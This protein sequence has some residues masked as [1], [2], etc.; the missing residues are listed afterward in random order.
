MKISEVHIKNFRAIKDEIISFD[1]ITT[2]IGPNGAGKSTILRALDWFFNGN[3]KTNELVDDDVNCFSEGGDIEVDITFKDLSDLDRQQLGKYAPPGLDNLT[4]RKIREFQSGDEYLSANSKGYPLFNE[5]KTA[6]TKTLK[7]DL[8]NSLVSSN[9]ELGLE[10]V[11]SGAKAEEEITAWES[12]NSE[13]LEEIP[14]KIVTQF[15]GFNGEGV[16]S[17]VFDYVLIDADLRAADESE[18]AKGSILSKIIDIFVDRSAGADEIKKI[19]E[20]IVSEHQEKITQK[21]ESSLSTLNNNFNKSI[22]HYVSGRTIN[23]VPTPLEVKAGK[24]GFSIQI[25]DGTNS[26]SVARQGH[27]FQRT[28]IIS[29]LQMLANEKNSEN[30]RVIF[31][32]IEEPE[33]YQ[34]PIQARNFA[35]VLRD[36]VLLDESSGTQIAY[37]THSPFFLEDNAFHQVRRVT[38]TN[39]GNL[40]ISSS[41]VESV[42]GALEQVVNEASVRSQLSKIV[43]GTL[44]EALFANV[45][46]LVEGTTEQAIFYGIADR[47]SPGALE[48]LGISI[49]P[50]NGKSN[51]PLYRE[52]LKEM[53]I[54]VY[55]LFD[56]DSNCEENSRNS[57]KNIDQINAD[58]KNNHRMNNNILGVLGLDK[59]DIPSERV[60]E[61]YAVFEN[62]LEYFMISNWPQWAGYCK[63]LS[64]RTG[65]NLSKNSSI[66]RRGTMEAPGE[67]PSFLKNIIDNIVKMV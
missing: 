30:D 52:I 31:L 19:T 12:K 64:E 1:D 9:P 26:T 55:I 23:I 24:T 35:K 40:S 4:I 34:H 21:Y 38:R 28:L 57:G 36:L 51:F 43:Q 33:L 13:K 58:I 10:K 11:S 63:D 54:P 56:A 62:N 8:Y 41:S 18:D 45:V 39:E 66:Y 47:N 14:E 5:I 48:S 22:N 32:A 60:E 15:F 37:A 27:G 50:C 61:E 44:S 65:A 53:G 20:D 2:F 59:C 6:A 25:N 29:A 42:V 46:F 67:V 7:K 17:G 3:F 16:L 49:V